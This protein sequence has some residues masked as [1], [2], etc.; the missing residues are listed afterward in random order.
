MRT[1][2]SKSNQNAAAPSKSTTSSNIR[3]LRL[4]RAQNYLLLWV[5]TSIDQKN[6]DYE[7]TLKQ[8]R[9]ITNDVNV[10]TQRD[11]CIDYLTDLQEDVK[12]F[13]VVKDTMSQQ[14]M[15]L[16]NDIPQ[17]DSVYILNDIETVHEEWIKKCN[18][19]RPIRT[20]INDICKG[21]QSDI[22][23]YNQDSI[24]MSFITANEMTSTDNLNQLEPNFMYTQIFKEI[25]LDMQHDEQ[26]IKQFT[27]YCRHHDCGSAKNINEF[28]KDYQ[29][30]SAIWWY[31][32]PSF[33]YSMLNYALRS[34][35]GDTIINMGFF[36]HDLH[37]QIQQ[38]HQQQLT[39]YADE[40]FIVYRGQGLSKANFEKLQNTNG[41]LLSFNNFLSTSTEQNISLIFAH[42][43]SDN[44][45]TIGILFKIFIDP[46]VK[47]VPFASIKQMS[48]YNQEEE[49]LF[50]MHT[51]F[52]VG[53]IR[54]FGNENQLYQVELQL[55]SD[56]DQQLRVLTDGIREETGGDTG[57][58]RL[59]DLL[60]KIGQFN[61][62]EE[63]YNA[64]LEQ[65]S[66]ENE[67][68]IYYGC[69]GHVHYNQGA[70][71]KAI[72]CYEQGLEIQQKTL[73][74]NHPFLA[75]S[76][77]SISNVYAELGEYSKALSFHE[78]ALE[79]YQKSLPS[80]HPHLAASYSNIGFVYDNMG[81]Y[82]KALSYYQ[83][84]LEIHQKSLPS[85]H[86]NLATTYNNIGYA[87]DNTGD[88]SKALSFHEKALEIRQKTLPS[89]HP[90]IPQSYSNIGIVYDNTGDYSKAL[91]FHEKALE[92]REKALPTNHPDIG[93]S[94]CCIGSVY[95]NMGDYSKA[96][97][98]HEKAL[99]IY[100]KSLPSNHPHLATSYY[101]IGS[102]Y[103]NMGEYSK[104]LSSHEKA[105]HIRVETLPSN[106]SDL[107][108]SYYN[109]GSVYDKMEEYPKAL[110]FYDKEFEIIQ[111]SVPSNHR[112]LA[113][114][115]SSI[116]RMHYHM[117]E[118]SKALSF[119]EKDL[120]ICENSLPSN[121]PDLATSYYNI[122]SVYNNMGEYSKA[123]SFHEKAI[124][125]REK[126]LSSNHLDLATSYSNIGSV[127][128]NM[129]EYSKALSFFEK[130]IDIREKTLSSNH[131]SLA[132]SYNKIGLIDKT[133]L[134]ADHDTS[135]N[136]YDN[137]LSNSSLSMTIAESSVDRF[138][139]DLLKFSA[140]KENVITWIDEIE[141]Q[142]NMMHLSNASKLNLIRICLNG[143]A[144]QWFKQH[145][146]KF[147]SWT[148][149]IN[150]IKKSFT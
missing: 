7:N 48:Y 110:T 1:S 2:E 46:R 91:S 136:S 45:D 11:A 20:N 119:F 62:A 79:I 34:M 24:A 74:S 58:Q 148:I 63:L 75:W 96:L 33:I 49:I 117:E 10:F 143:D 5:D 19:I 70:Y 102:V 29:P 8:I 61:K 83:N 25:L 71:E 149:F 4:R 3:Q 18:K 88:Y 59:G 93:T 86:P 106:H 43:A 123:L 9:T 105:L 57:W 31:T 99:E 13:L 14:I 139:T 6:E 82:S 90:D 125:I 23:Q 16:I 36:I 135:P 68:A 66:D 132:T 116:G 92:I 41:A 55:T 35:E 146:H 30:E 50:S 133:I 27:A 47:S 112:D 54:E 38:L 108:T 84:A 129:S 53:A 78:K 124:D 60:L 126:T 103:N 81:E 131:P 140:Q 65:P 22:K 77:N 145:K 137:H 101:N 94:Y 114:S 100:Q 28:E 107:A 97:S 64:L 95:D 127:Y 98:S 141:Q 40:P 138:I 44:V 130:A 52:R 121:H 32:S 113:T 26:A 150:E 120:E 76:Y 12:S 69:L 111:Q 134:V 147:T 73:P 104:A 87:Y 56:D 39:S 37:Q 109:I 142:F 144:L 67:K 21:L 89:N 122:G 115:Y 51:V 118:Y 72:W 17:L 85:N 15:P 80:N 128:D 42:S